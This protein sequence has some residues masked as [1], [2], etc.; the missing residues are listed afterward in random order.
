LSEARDRL[1]AAIDTC[2]KA[3]HYDPFS[4]ARL[5]ERAIPANEFSWR[6]CAYKAVGEYERANPS[7]APMYNSLINQDHMMA[8]AIMHGQMTR[9]ER[10]V[11]YL[12][13]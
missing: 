1:T 6:Q 8:N 11:G 9:S 4:P 7:L 12:H 5:P 3:Y 2:S 13:C 10:R